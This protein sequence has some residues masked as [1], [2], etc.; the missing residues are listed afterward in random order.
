MGVF[1]FR[2]LRKQSDFLGVDFFTCNG[3]K[4]SQSGNLDC[5]RTAESAAER[6]RAVLQHV[7]SDKFVTCLL[8]YVG[9]A[10]LV[11]AVLQVTVAADV[12]DVQRN[13]VGQSRPFDVDFVSAVCADVNGVFK[14]QRGRENFTATVVY[15]LADDVYAACRR[16]LVIV[17]IFLQSRSP[18]K[19]LLSDARP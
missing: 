10:C 7:A 11:V 13:F 8:P 9:A 3:S 4:R 14:G 1:A 12:C 17:I 2:L 5:R 18:S 19:I 6:H 16:H 15:V